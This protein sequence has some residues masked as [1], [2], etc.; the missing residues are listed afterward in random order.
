[1]LGESRGWEGICRVVMGGVFEFLSLRDEIG[2]DDA[3]IAELYVALVFGE[4][5]CG[6]FIC[7]GILM[8]GESCGWDRMCRVVVGGVLEFFS[9]RDE[10][11][12]DDAGI[13]ELEVVF[14]RD[15]VVSIG[16]VV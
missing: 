5:V 8:L 6:V 15:E 3:G 2:R 9:L 4:D 1:M 7:S 12:R 11:G 16:D 10:I 14:T 13:A